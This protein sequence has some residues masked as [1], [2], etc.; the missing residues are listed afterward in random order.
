MFTQ[1][2]LEINY[3]VYLI[4]LGQLQEVIHEMRMREVEFPHPAWSRHLERE[5]I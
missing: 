5:R 1:A 4:Q 2:Q 3:V